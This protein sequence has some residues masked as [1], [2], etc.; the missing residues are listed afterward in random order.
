MLRYL[1]GAAFSDGGTRSR[2][3]AEF[4]SFVENAAHTT[5]T[6][7]SELIEYKALAMGNRRHTVAQPQHNTR[8]GV[9]GRS[10]ITGVYDLIGAITSGGQK[11]GH[12]SLGRGMI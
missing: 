6:S 9:A 4:Q 2:D 3:T 5:R 11:F 8:F 12:Q 1:L 10:D 7:A